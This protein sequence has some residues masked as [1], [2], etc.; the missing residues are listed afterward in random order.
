MDDHLVPLEGDWA[1]RRDFAVRSAGFPVS[2][3]DVFGSD[4]EQARLRDVAGD[5]A[6]REAVA[7]QNRDVLATAVDGLLKTGGKPSTQRR[8][9]EIVARYWQRYCSKNDTIG[10]F[11]PLAWGEVRDDGPA[12][13]Q[14]SR[15]LVR[16]RTVHMETWCLER[17][18]QTV[19][20]DP[21]LPLAPWPEEDARA[22]IE[23]IQDAATRERA[24]TG[25]ARLV[26]ER[27]RIATAPRDGLG[28]ALDGFDRVFEDLV[29]EAPERTPELAGGGRT[30]VYL[31]AMR[32]LDV[33]LG[34][35]VVAEL[36]ASLGPLLES[37]RWLC[38]RSFE[39]GCELL[40]E[41]I[42]SGER[43]PLA[44]LF[45]KVF[46]AL[47]ELPRLLASEY[48]E[49]QRRWAELLDDPD[50]A[51]IGER[52]RARF[53]DY[54][55]AW[56]IS[57]FHSPDIQ[58]AAA[59]AGAVERGDY[60]VVIGDFHPGT[61][62]LGQGLF[63]YRHPDR[64]WFLE[65][66]GADIGTPGIYLLPPRVSE[67]PMTAR[68][69]PAANLP[70]DIIVL[71]GMPEVRARGGSRIVSLADVLV[72]GATI[73]DGEGSFRAP[74]HALF[75]VPM[76]VATAFSYEPFPGAEHMERITVGRTVYRRE[77]WRIAI[78]DCPSDP[79]DV[80]GWARDHGVPRRV[81]VR[82]ADEPKPSYL[83]V[84]SSVLVRIFCRQIRR[85]ADRPEQ[86]MTVS[87]ML[88]RPEDC[89]L[90]LGGERYTSELRIAAVDLTRR[91]HAKIDV[92]KPS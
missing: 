73:T 70:G 29:G 14:R 19:T 36:S 9:E 3:L 27:E 76:F 46:S 44:P 42:G 49:L 64:Q 25:L 4:G 32:D 80:A 31:D 48:A 30:P 16:E 82:M 81:F 57:V 91:G 23:S 90:E 69:M 1:L 18:L 6:F 8:R 24:A 26:T 37:S 89:W 78:G 52:A 50:H 45:G 35:G 12:L 40:N 15:A 5:P 67:V 84:E 47:R 34:P 33:A 55:P 13:A 22:R 54:G 61:N 2:G 51:T 20:D 59:D 74:L 53:S 38:G 66:L 65:T 85:R 88:P 92:R 28:E 83:D 77:S 87:E 11:G 71:P 41:A 60:L 68:L 62:P 72:D 58:I 43:R 17:F 79:A 7:W 75:W 56:P 21:W 10:F 39:L 86:L 63:A